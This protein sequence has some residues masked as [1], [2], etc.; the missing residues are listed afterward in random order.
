[1]VGKGRTTAARTIE[2]F[3]VGLSCFSDRPAEAVV[4]K[5]ERKRDGR[6]DESQQRNEQQNSGETHDTPFP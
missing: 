2:L 6:Y 1:L 4:R 5:P 3:A